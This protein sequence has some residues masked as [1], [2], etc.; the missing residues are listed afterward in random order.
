MNLLHDGLMDRLSAHSLFCH[1]L[2]KQK[3]KAAML[4]WVMFGF[5]H[6]FFKQWLSL[7]AVPV[8]LLL[9]TGSRIISATGTMHM[10]VEIRGIDQVF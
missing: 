9:M 3:Q 10:N 7:I 4:G 6:R 1:Y 8:A 2:A 5:F